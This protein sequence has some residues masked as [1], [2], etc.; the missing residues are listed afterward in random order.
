MKV[1]ERTISVLVRVFVQVVSLVNY[2][3]LGPCRTPR[4]PAP[5]SNPRTLCHQQAGP[6]CQGPRGG[7]PT[8]GPLCSVQALIT[9][10]DKI[11]MQPV[12]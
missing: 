2:P 7:C 6:V 5:T 3:P 8:N 4:H 9:E 1:R 10:E 11:E 12:P